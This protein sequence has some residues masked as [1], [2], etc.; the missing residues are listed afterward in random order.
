[1]RTIDSGRLLTSVR[2]ERAV[3]FAEFLDDGRTIAAAGPDGL[4][5]LVESDSG[6]TIARLQHDNELVDVTRLD[7]DTVATVTGA[8][9]LQIWDVRTSTPH[10]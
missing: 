4:L 3:T 10:P 9:V 8:G 5:L 2:L 1:M 6:R 7:A